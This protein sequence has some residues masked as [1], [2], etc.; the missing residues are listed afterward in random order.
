MD[1]H[2][3]GG[4]GIGIVEGWLAEEQR[5]TALLRE[6]LERISLGSVNSME[7]KEAL[8]KIARAALAG[9]RMGDIAEGV[10]KNCKTCGLSDRCAG[11]DEEPECWQPAASDRR[12][13]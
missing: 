5:R 10:T 8:G 13:T 4:A 1:V 6:A 9:A 3:M 2:D 7:S 12:V 11:H